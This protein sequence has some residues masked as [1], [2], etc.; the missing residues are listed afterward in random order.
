[1]EEA[2]PKDA[3]DGDAVGKEESDCAERGDGEECFGRADVD[4]GHKDREGAGYEDGVYWEVEIWVDLEGVSR[5]PKEEWVTNVR[6]PYCEGRTTVASK[7]V[8]FSG[9]AEPYQCALDGFDGTVSYVARL[10]PTFEAKIRMTKRAESALTTDTE[11][12]W[13]KT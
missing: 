10:Y 2:A 13:L 12:A 8:Q 7:S 4:Q 11:K 6:H 3:A 5:T 9:T 1:M